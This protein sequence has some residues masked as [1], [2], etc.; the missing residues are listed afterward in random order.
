MTFRAKL[1]LSFSKIVSHSAHQV[2]S[3]SSTLEIP[4]YTKKNHSDLQLKFNFSG[5]LS[6]ANTNTSLYLFYLK[7]VILD[8]KFSKKYV[9]RH[10]NLELEQV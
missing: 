3:K 7:K 2:Y 8:K 6:F 9:T 1:V 4:K 10:C 5:I